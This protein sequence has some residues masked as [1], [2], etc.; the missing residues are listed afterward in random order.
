MHLTSSLLLA[1]GAAFTL[2]AASFPKPCRIADRF[3]SLTYV[4]GSKEWSLVPNPTFAESIDLEECSESDK[5]EFCF[6]PVNKY[7]NQ[8]IILGPGGTIDYAKEFRKGELVEKCNGEKW[9]EV[10]H[11]RAPGAKKPGDRSL[12]AN[13]QALLVHSS[14]STVYVANFQEGYDFVSKCPW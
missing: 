7:D 12:W 13:N 11:R 6:I 10:C 3:S 1:S 8:G 2:V 14:G 4:P 5:K 9:R